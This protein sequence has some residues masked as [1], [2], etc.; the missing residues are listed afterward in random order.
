M[1]MLTDE[2]YEQLVDAAQGQ[3]LATI[4]REVLAR[5]LKSRRRR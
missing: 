2:E 5:W 4:A 1:V 3:P